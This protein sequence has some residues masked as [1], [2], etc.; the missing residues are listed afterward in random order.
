GC[1]SLVITT[2]AFDPAAIAITPIFVQNC[3]PA[4]VGVDTLVLSAATGCDSLVV[5]TTTLAPISQT[6]LTAASCN[7]NLVGTD[8]L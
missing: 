8:T 7:P 3:D 6:F 5:T 2:T 1:D 4:A